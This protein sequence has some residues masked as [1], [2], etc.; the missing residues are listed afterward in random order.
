MSG[1]GEDVLREYAEKREQFAETLRKKK[2]EEI[3]SK[4]RAKHDL[5]S[6]AHI[7]A[8]PSSQSDLLVTPWLA[9]SIAAPNPNGSGHD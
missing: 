4:K 3:L 1:S 7:P 5:Q 2:R 9:D 8:S 6:K